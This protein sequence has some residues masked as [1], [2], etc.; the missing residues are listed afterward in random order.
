MMTGCIE[1]AATIVRVEQRGN[2]TR[3]GTLLLSRNYS[4]EEEDHRDEMSFHFFMERPRE[5][6]R[7]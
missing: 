7:L 6:E 4:R 5:F 2:A 1:L 3:C